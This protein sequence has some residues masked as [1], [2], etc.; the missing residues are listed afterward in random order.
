MPCSIG[1]CEAVQGGIRSSKW[2]IG[3]APMGLG[4]GDSPLHAPRRTVA[5]SS[6]QRRASSAASQCANAARLAERWTGLAGAWGRGRRRHGAGRGYRRT[7]EAAAR[8]MATEG[9]AS[10]Q[11]HTYEMWPTHMKLLY[12]ASSFSFFSYRAFRGVFGR[13]TVGILYFLNV[14]DL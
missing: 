13:P 9:L 7:A 4:L 11:L 2:R 1:L 12:I 8:T 6:T 10:W 5:V 3:A 14:P